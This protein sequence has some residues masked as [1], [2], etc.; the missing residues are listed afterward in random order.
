MCRTFFL[1]GILS[2]HVHKQP[3]STRQLKRHW[4]DLFN[5]LSEKLIIS[6]R[7]YLSCSGKFSSICNDLVTKAVACFEVNA[8]ISSKSYQRHY[9]VSRQKKC[10]WLYFL[11]KSFHREG[12]ITWPD[13][14]SNPE[15]LTYHSS[16]L[17]TELLSNN[18]DLW[19]FPFFPES[20][21]NHAR[22]NETVP[23]LMD[24]LKVKEKAWLT[25][26]G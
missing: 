21:L 11:F 18:V 15:P 16:F 7:L 2:N 20:T 24:S 5:N 9:G 10:S 3:T 12:K 22:T 4:I 23:L 17:P 19:Q 1:L 26:P 25:W 6:V 14:N 8:N 13:R